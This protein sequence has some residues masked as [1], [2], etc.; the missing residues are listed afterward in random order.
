MKKT[1]IAQIQVKA[2]DVEKFIKLAKQMVK[3]SNNEK[4]CITYELFNH[5]DSK[6]RFLFFEEYSNQEAV[7]Y[8]NTS[9]HFHQFLSDVTNMLSSEPIITNY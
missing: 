6:G 2:N 5:I 1:I 8:H 4:G 3:T 9:D 7:N